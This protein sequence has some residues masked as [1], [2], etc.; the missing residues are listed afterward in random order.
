MKFRI[1]ATGTYDIPEDTEKRLLFYGTAVPSEMAKVDEENPVWDLLEICDE[2]SVTY[3][4]EV[5]EEW[6]ET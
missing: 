1:T 5:V 2:D 4:V 6:N 3:K